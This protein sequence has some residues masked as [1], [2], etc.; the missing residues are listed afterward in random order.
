MFE[1]LIFLLILGWRSDFDCDRLPFFGPSQF[2]AGQFGHVV[3][4]RAA[5]SEL[6]HLQGGGP[7]HFAVDHEQAEGGGRNKPQRGNTISGGA[8]IF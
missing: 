8:N 2:G 7:T 3:F 1:F 5:L 4:V 6:R